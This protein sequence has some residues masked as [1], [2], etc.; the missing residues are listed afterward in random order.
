[1]NSDGAKM[2]PESPIPMDRLVARIFPK[3]STIR[4]QI[5]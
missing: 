4:N 2:P 3:A 1:M 5:A